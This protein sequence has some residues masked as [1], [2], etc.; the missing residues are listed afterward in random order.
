MDKKN[1]WIKCDKC[2]E[3]HW[4]SDQSQE[5]LKKIKAQGAC[6]EGAIKDFC[7]KCKVITWHEL[8]DLKDL[9]W[10]PHC[11]NTQFIKMDKKTDVK[12]YHGSM[13]FEG[14]K[15]IKSFELECT[16][17]NCHPRFVYNLRSGKIT[18]R[19]R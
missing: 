18:E 17:P 3:I 19:K 4:R 7:P 10:C 14:W 13:G 16:R 2:G 9:K 8:N 6:Y 1:K 15:Q 12:S 5:D 11:G